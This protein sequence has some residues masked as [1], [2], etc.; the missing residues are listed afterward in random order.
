MPGKMPRGDERD[1]VMADGGVTGPVGEHSERLSAA[2]ERAGESAT[3]ARQA[4]GVDDERTQ[5]G[6]RPDHRPAKRAEGREAGGRA[7]VTRLQA[8]TRKATDHDSVLSQSD[9]IQRALDIIRDSV[10]FAPT[11]V[12]WLVDI[13]PSAMSWGSEIHSDVRRFYAEVVP[14]LMAATDRLQTGVVTISR[15][16]EFRVKR[17][18][19]P[20]V[21][22]A[23]WDAMR[24]ESSGRETT[25]EAVKQALDE[26][27]PLR[28]RERREVVLVIITDEAG[29]DW[30]QV[31]RLIEQPGKYALPIYVVG[32]PAPLG[33]T[34]ALD[35]GIE[36]ST[37]GT[38]TRA[39]VGR[40]ALWQPILQGPESRA[41]EAIQL[42]FEEFSSSLELLDSGFGPF[43]LEWLCR[44][45]GG[46]FLAVRGRS[47]G[48]GVANARRQQWPTVDA[49]EFN[50][51]IMRSY[52]AGL[53]GRNIVSELIA[54]QCRVPR[55][56]TTPHDCRGRRF[57]GTRSFVLKSATRPT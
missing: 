17:T 38:D 9:A 19:D 48:S 34:A 3:C 18:T 53:G 1:W 36:S 5:D 47:L 41:G 23:A 43:G 14:T 55:S 25:F 11:T 15:T 32:V 4:A 6:H 31:D 45:S 52:A 46:S 44:A 16:V 35:P 2:V 40:T 22:V 10:D 27:L 29:D 20:Q 57:C 42:E 33:R 24:I 37:E 21:V 13:S 8:R 50:A 54:G 28:I 12:V 56:S 30:A 7:A 49:G 51:Q 39:A 26:Y